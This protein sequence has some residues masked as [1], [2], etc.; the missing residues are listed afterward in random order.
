MAIILEDPKREE[1]A[2]AAPRRRWLWGLLAAAVLAAGLKSRGPAVADLLPGLPRAQHRLR[3]QDFIQG[4]PIP[5]E[6]MRLVVSVLDLNKSV[7]AESSKSAFGV[8]LGTTRVSLSVPARVHY[9]V[10][11]SGKAPVTFRIDEAR[12]TFV[13]EFP[14]PEVQAVEILSGGKKTY[15]E[16]GW[17][18]MK[19]LSGRA[20]EEGLE[21]GLYDSVRADA[22]APAALADIRVRARPVLARFVADYLRKAGASD[23]RGGFTRMRV[24]FKGDED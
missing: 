4:I 13:A 10:D 8:D 9:A 14:D 12:Q 2:A 17:A 24:K 19:A 22:A 21:R 3:V 11:L 5:R 18:R 1:R 7:S 23:G 6:D 16:A 15:V 20:L